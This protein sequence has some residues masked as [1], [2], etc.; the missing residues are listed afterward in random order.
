LTVA[1]IDIKAMLHSFWSYPPVQAAIRGA[2]TSIAPVLLADLH[3]FTTWKNLDD[4]AKFDWK[5]AAL[6]L[7]Q[8]A[9]AGAL[10]GLGLGAVLG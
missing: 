1:V 8:G 2:L 9:V 7:T 5:I 6:R 3:S 4:A 10:A